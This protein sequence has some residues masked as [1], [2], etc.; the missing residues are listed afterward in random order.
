MNTEICR[1]DDF[2]FYDEKVLQVERRPH[3]VHSVIPSR[4]CATPPRE[5]RTTQLHAIPRDCETAIKT[6]EMQ[7]SIPPKRVEYADLIYKTSVSSRLFSAMIW[8]IKRFMRTIR[9]DSIAKKILQGLLCIRDRSKPSRIIDNPHLATF[10][11]EAIAPLSAEAFER[12]SADC[13]KT[14]TKMLQPPAAGRK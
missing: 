5:I 9:F 6:N 1:A 11:S 2:T 12:L 13:Q 4:S 7:T 3:T 10:Y 14:G 8:P